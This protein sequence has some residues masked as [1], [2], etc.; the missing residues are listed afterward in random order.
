MDWEEEGIN[1]CVDVCSA[2]CETREEGICD[3]ITGQD[4]LMKLMID[5]GYEAILPQNRP[6][7]FT[8]SHVIHFAIGIVIVAAGT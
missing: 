7:V 5:W 4:H 2:E 1:S 8:L 3:K 6:P